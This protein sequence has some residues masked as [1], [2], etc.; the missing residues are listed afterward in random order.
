MDTVI[1]HPQRVLRGRVLVEIAKRYDRIPVQVAL[2]FLSQHPN[3]FTIAKTSRPERARENNNGAGWELTPE[4]LATIDRTFP[5]P[6]EDAS[7]EMI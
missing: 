3:I 5:V 4:D 6:D 7:L 1:F 2:N